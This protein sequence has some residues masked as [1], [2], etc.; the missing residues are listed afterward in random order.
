[1]D[2]NQIYDVMATLAEECRQWPTPSVT[3]IAEQHRTAFHVLISCI[4]SLRTKDAV[5]A[6]ASM[7]LFDR[8]GSPQEMALLTP[9]EIGDL[10]YPA[11][12]YRVKGEQI[13]QICVTLS[14]KYA[15][16]VPDSIEQLLEFKGVGRKTANLVLTLGHAKPG[17]CVD[18]HVHRITNRWGY[19]SSRTPD[20]TE[21]VLRGKLPVEFWQIINDLLVSYGQ[22]ICYPVSPACSRCRLQIWCSKVG[23]QRSR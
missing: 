2:D 19:V 21:Q 15:G 23:V 10:I 16:T 1:M 18:V 12:F 5:T 13:Y 7:R 20:Q 6:A 9:S 17:I 11:G 4:I 22:N 8:A 3:V 14:E